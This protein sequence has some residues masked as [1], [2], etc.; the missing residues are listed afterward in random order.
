MLLSHTLPFTHSLLQD[1]LVSQSDYVRS[2]LK[3]LQSEVQDLE[4]RAQDIEADIRVSMSNGDKIK[5]EELMQEWFGLLNKKNEFIK[6]QL[7]LNM[8]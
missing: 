8:M 7:Q 4:G 6:R 5:E 2:E 3:S 1:L